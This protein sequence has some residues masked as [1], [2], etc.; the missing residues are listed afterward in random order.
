[1]ADAATSG[2]GPGQPPD[3]SWELAAGVV[4]PYLFTLGRTRPAPG[5]DLPVEAMVTTTPWGRDRAGDL[6]PERRAVVEL[7]SHPLSIAEVASRLSAPLGV[8]R[9]LVGDLADDALVE[10]DDTRTDLAADVQLLQRLIARVR[11]IPA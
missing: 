9:V 10:A 5:R 7:C 3:D 8:I 11:A 6:P 4:R 2:R 1:M